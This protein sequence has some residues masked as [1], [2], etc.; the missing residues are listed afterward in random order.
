MRTKKKESN[1]H[2]KIQHKSMDYKKICKLS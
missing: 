1:F 2:V